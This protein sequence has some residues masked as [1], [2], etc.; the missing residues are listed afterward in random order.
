MG[1]GGGVRACGVFGL[2]VSTLALASGNAVAAAPVPGGPAEP[3][4]E[5]DTD[6]ATGFGECAA[7]RERNEKELQMWTPTQPAVP[8]AYAKRA[9][10]LDAPWANLGRG[11][12][13][14]AGVIVTTILPNLGVMF[15][16]ALPEFLISFPWQFV[17]GPPL[18]CSRT[19]GSFDVDLHRPNRLVLEPGFAVAK[20]GTTFSIRPGYR[21]LVHPASWFVG[22]GGGLGTTLEIV[23]R[24]PFRPS[25]SPEAIVQLGA[26]CSAGYFTIAV[27]GDF[28]FAGQNLY[29]LALSFGVTYF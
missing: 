20:D 8:F 13:D 2:V 17:L 3:A 11:I 26:C 15:R 25:L 5:T 10:V 21:F 14:A 19:R 29:D 22:I 18:S 23:G 9:L 12:A 1:Y 4:P 7:L 28:F 16:G 24:E 27:R 6:R